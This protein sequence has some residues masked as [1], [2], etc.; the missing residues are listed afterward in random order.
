MSVEVKSASCDG[1]KDLPVCMQF[2]EREPL[3]ARTLPPMS[4]AAPAQVIHRLDR[5]PMIPTRGE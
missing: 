1:V 2:H 3:T 4:A 5:I